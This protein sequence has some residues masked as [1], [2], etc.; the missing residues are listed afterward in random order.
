[1]DTLRDRQLLEELVERGE[2]PW[3]T[4]NQKRR[5]QRTT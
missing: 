3:L 1:M 4:H 5:S 2:M